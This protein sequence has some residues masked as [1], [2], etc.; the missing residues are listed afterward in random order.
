MIGIIS[1]KYGIFHQI[2]RGVSRTGMNLV[3]ENAVKQTT[4]FSIPLFK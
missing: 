3:N 2:L 4:F 1:H